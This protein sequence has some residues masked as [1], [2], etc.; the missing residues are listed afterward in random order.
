MTEMVCG[1]VR[2]M[3]AS[4]LLTDRVRVAMDDV[5][6]SLLDLTASQVIPYSNPSDRV[7]IPIE[8]A[9]VIDDREIHGHEDPPFVFRSAFLYPADDIRIGAS[10]HAE[11][12]DTAGRNTA[13]R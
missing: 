8:S 3:I 7:A 4:L 6:L 5:R 12:A 1:R 13:L 10:R 9:I 2:V 11:V